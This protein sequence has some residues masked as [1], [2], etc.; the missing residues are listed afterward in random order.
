MALISKWLNIKLIKEENEV[1]KIGIWNIHHKTLISSKEA[2]LSS[3]SYLLHSF[4]LPNLFCFVFIMHN[5]AHK[6]E[7]IVQVYKI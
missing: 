6:I 5:L 3:F 4:I 7:Y 2:A 1:N